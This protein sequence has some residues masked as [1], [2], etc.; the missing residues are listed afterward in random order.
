MF[1]FAEVFPLILQ[2]FI[3]MLTDLHFLPLFLVIM[4]IIA[5]QYR[6][7]EKIKEELF[8]M[9]NSGFW[10]DVFMSTGFGLLGGLVG[11]FLM[12][13]IGLSLS[14]SGLIYLW[15]IAILLMLINV[16]FLCFA[17]SGGILSLSS[18]LLGFPQ[19][20]VSQIIALVAVLHIV[21]SL[22][23]LAGGHL[24]AAPAYIKGT[25]G[26]V[27]G[28]FTLQ[29]FWP[30]PLVVLAVAGAGPIQ[31]GVEMPS[32][33]PLIKPGLPGDPQ[34][35][36]YTLMPVIAGLG[37]GDMAMARSPVEKSRL[38]AIYLGVY[39]LLLLILAVLAEHS[40]VVMLTAA[41]F[42]PLGHEAVV[43]ISRRF[44][45]MNEPL[46]VAPDRGV[47][48]L[49]VLPGGVA[50]RAG[51]RSGD[52]ILAINDEDLNNKSELA[53]FQARAIFQQRVDYYSHAAG[54][55]R[56]GFLAPANPGRHWDMLPVPEGNEDIYIELLQGGLLGSWLQKL[57][58]VLKG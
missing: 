54:K 4:I 45:F 21:E 34:N 46:Y 28:G 7:A 42:S 32:W 31:G 33:W 12:V 16:R 37:Y 38:S 43:L 6:R 22:L 57:W 52:I 51:I 5:M 19:V 53:Q 58:R 30:I 15:P 13:F 9:K 56:R 44:E 25:G 10:A 41:L 39:S 36:V 29:K 40:R 18:L 2:T 20:N 23:I 27:T 11:S 26:K 50:W 1:P 14:E 3:Q 55:I 35:M 49:D 47:K 48:V 17:Y 8:G 24:G